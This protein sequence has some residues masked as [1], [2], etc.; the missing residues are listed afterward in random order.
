ML[1]MPAPL[2]QNIFNNAAKV[3]RY[4]AQVDAYLAQQAEIEYQYQQSLDCRHPGRKAR[5]ENSFN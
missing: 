1:K 5:F 4:H 3:A 2:N